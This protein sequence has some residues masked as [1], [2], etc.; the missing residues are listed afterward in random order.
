MYVLACCFVF[1]YRTTAD[2]LADF[3]RA[4]CTLHN[5]PLASAFRGHWSVSPL[6]IGIVLLIEFYGWPL[7]PVGNL[8]CQDRLCLQLID[9]DT[10]LDM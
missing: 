9:A 10:C 8:K 1:S 6:P 2:F 5:V 7:L 4:C 3:L